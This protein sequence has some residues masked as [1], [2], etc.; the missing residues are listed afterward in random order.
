VNFPSIQAGCTFRSLRAPFHLFVVLTD[1]HPADDPQVIFVNLTTAREGSD[2][3]V[4]LFAG[5]H[6]R[7][8]HES[9]VFYREARVVPVRKIEYLLSLKAFAPEAPIRGDLLGEMLAGV[10]ISLWTSPKVKE[11]LNSLS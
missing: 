6:P 1:P 5:D 11:F 8:E 4:V 3:T 9:V 10:Q 7:I 2:R